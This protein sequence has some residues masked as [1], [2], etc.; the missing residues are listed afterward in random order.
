MVEW[1]WSSVISLWNAV[2]PSTSWVKSEKVCWLLR[3][4]I[5]VLRFQVW[6]GSIVSTIELFLYVWEKEEPEEIL[7]AELLENEIMNCEEGEVI[8]CRRGL[9]K[10][11]VKEFVWVC[12]GWNC[13]MDVVSLFLLSSW[14]CGFHSKVV[15]ILCGFL[16]GLKLWWLESIVVYGVW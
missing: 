13:S 9:E 2:C 6:R 1:R 14:P 3:R 10:V 8:V 16:L 7:V 11:L 12:Q 15:H 4:S 5:K